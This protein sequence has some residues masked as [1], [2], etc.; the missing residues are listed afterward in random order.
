MAGVCG[1][2]CVSCY[3]RRWHLLQSGKLKEGGMGGGKERNWEGEG[4]ALCI[5]KGNEK[6]KEIR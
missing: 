1:G 4:K 5:G 6:R 2:A 3:L